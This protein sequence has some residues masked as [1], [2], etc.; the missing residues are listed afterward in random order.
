MVI[1]F[2]SF[3]V[4][5]IVFVTEHATAMILFTWGRTWV[6]IN[7]KRLNKVF[8]VLPQRP[9]S[10]TK[11]FCSYMDLHFETHVMTDCYLKYL[12]NSFSQKRKRTPSKSHKQVI[13]KS[14]KSGARRAGSTVVQ[15]VESPLVML[16]SHMSSSSAESRLSTSNL[17]PCY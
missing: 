6:T 15:Q 14:S 10:I 3:I 1:Y 2:F 13:L 4:L 8:F 12:R 17:V 16:A 7:V 11:A 9:S 5:L